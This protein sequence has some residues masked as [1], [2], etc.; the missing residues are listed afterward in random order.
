MPPS[1]IDLGVHPR[2]LAALREDA[3]NAVALTEDASA[4]YPA[5]SPI[6]A[7]LIG[8]SLAGEGAAKTSTTLR[9]FGVVRPTPGR[10]LSEDLGESSPKPSDFPSIATRERRN[11]RA[12]TIQN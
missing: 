3:Q 6:A 7:W 1:P 12:L 10:T 11:L 4:S 5:S 2:V 9:V 8:L